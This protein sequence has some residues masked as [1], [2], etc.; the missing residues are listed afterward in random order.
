MARNR[1][2]AARARKIGRRPRAREIRPAGTGGCAAAGRRRPP[3]W[4]RGSWSRRP[5]GG[6]GAGSGGASRR[7]RPLV[8]L[9]WPV[10]LHSEPGLRQVRSCPKEERLPRR[11]GSRSGRGE[12]LHAAASA[13]PR[14]GLPRAGLPGAEGTGLRGGGKWAALSPFASP[15]PIRCALSRSR[16]G[17]HSLG[18]FME[19]LNR[20]LWLQEQRRPRPPACRAA[21]RDCFLSGLSGLSC[22]ICPLPDFR[23]L[24]GPP[25]SLEGLL[26]QKPRR[27]RSALPFL[28]IQQKNRVHSYLGSPNTELVEETLFSPKVRWEGG[29]QGS[30]PLVLQS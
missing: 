17:A 24:G 28:L 22:G 5:A 27:N 25:W 10:G 13:R 12:S 30:C 9:A 8:G 2:G 21:A 20:P 11:G 29:S 16:W 3:F 19:G 18:V 7:R 14:V 6:E 26:P 15:P 23:S 1:R 4:R